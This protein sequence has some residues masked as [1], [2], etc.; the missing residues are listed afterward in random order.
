MRFLWS[1]ETA[2]TTPQTHGARSLDR[3]SSIASR[4]RASSAGSAPLRIAFLPAPSIAQHRLE[5]ALG[6]PAQLPLDLG[7]V[8]PE[9][10]KITLAARRDAI[11]KPLAGHPLKGSDHLQHRNSPIERRCGRQMVAGALQSHP[12]PLR[13]LLGWRAACISTDDLHRRSRVPSSV[14]SA[15][16]AKTRC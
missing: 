14:P 9:G 16:T 12:A 10:N 6:A 11:R 8:G 2:K 7:S 3:T 15:T 4:H 13:S 5:P 1:N